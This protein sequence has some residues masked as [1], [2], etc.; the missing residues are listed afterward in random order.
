MIPKLETSMYKYHIPVCHLSPCLFVPH[1]IHNFPI[2]LVFAIC[3]RGGID[4]DIAAPLDPD[5]RA[6]LR[7]EFCEDSLSARKLG[8]V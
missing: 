1:H 7:F 5:G 6:E 3:K 2:K 8:V 4:Y